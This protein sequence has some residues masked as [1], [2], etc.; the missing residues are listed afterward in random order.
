MASFVAVV[1]GFFV[2]VVIV[3]VFFL[4]GRGCYVLFKKG[5]VLFV[6]LFFSFFDGKSVMSALCIYYHMCMFV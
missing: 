3:F 2:V 6:C 5:F 4:G 1:V